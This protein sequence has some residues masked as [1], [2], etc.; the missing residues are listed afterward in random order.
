M[1]IAVSKFI[2]SGV[3]EEVV[4]C[5]NEFISQIFPVDKKNGEIRIILNLKPLNLHVSYEHFKMEHL[6][7]ALGLMGKDCFMASIDLTDAYYS[8][9]VEE[10]FRKYLRFIWNGK[11]YQYTCLAQGLSCAPRIFTKIMK[12]IFGKLRSEGFLSV[13]YLDDSLLIGKSL[14]ECIENVSAT[15]SLITNAGFIINVAKSQFV[16]MKEINFLGFVLNSS[17]MTVSLPAE[18]RL[19]IL[20]LCKKFIHGGRY[21]IRDVASLIG[22]LISSLPGVQY[23]SLFCKFLE[24]DKICALKVSKG[25][26]D[27]TMTLSVE[28]VDE[29]RWWIRNVQ[30]SVNYIRTPP[31][32]IIITT[33]ASLL[34]WGCSFG[35]ATAGGQ[36]SEREA[37]AH[38]NVLE[39]R[40]ILLGLKSFLSDY[41]NSHIRIRSDSTTAVSYINNFGGV[42]S[43]SCHKVAKEI[44]SWAFTGGNYLSAEHL[45]GRENVQ[46]DKASRIFDENTEWQLSPGIFTEISQRF[47]PFDVDLFASRLNNQC[48]LY[49]SWKPDPS[50]SYVDAFTVDWGK[51]NNPYLF[52]PFSVIMRCLQKICTDKTR[53][54]L[55]TPLWSTQPWFPKMMHMLVE[56]PVVLPLNV[57]RLPFKRDVVHKQHK[58]LRLIACRLSGSSMESNSFLNKQSPL[59]VLPGGTLPNFSIK[60]ILKNGFIS[61]VKGNLIPC[62][63]MR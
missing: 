51:I 14:L 32:S 49:C 54:T 27:G 61:V 46:A 9:N 17:S 2:N 37:C 59:S 48:S 29:L 5:E 35:E 10:S 20:E 53:A 63:T 24:Y 28:S 33:D 58:N 52:P 19:R 13:Y 50:A 44:W 41:K 55:I 43:L 38:I 16:P 21:I 3:I 23:G 6:N 12:P 15:K 56:P 11:L 22:L 60:Y 36:W 47:G 7:L 26:F 31:P 8:V 57:L 34:G 39:L 25:D 30:T 4:H 45:P 40:A 42:K 18:K 62:Y 1:D